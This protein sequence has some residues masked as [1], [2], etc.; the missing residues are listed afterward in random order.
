MLKCKNCDHD[1]LIVSKQVNKKGIAPREDVG[2]F[3]N[4]CIS[5]FNNDGTEDT[6]PARALLKAAEKSD[7]MGAVTA[8]L[9]EHELKMFRNKLERY[10]KINNPELDYSRINYLLDSMTYGEQLELAL[11]VDKEECE[12]TLKNEKWREKLKLQKEIS[13]K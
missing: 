2:Y 11:E 9:V 6:L 5:V 13:R 8:Y 7:L 4:K 1:L 10:L 3:C 12:R